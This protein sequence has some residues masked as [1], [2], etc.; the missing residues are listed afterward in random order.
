MN[1]QSAILQ[2]KT[3]NDPSNSMSQKQTSVTLLLKEDSKPR[4]KNQK[5]SLMSRLKNRNQNTQLT[6]G[7][8]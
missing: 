7:S 1:Q 5:S 8:T 2:A 3:M 4:E 6:Q